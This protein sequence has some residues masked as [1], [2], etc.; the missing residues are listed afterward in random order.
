M[1]KL[2]VFG[3]WFPV[4]NTGVRT[5]ESAHHWT[6]RRNS[7]LACRNPISHPIIKSTLELHRC[8]VVSGKVFAVFANWPDLAAKTRVTS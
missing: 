7:F 2:T 4:W 5:G 6:M 3:T 1:G 8:Y